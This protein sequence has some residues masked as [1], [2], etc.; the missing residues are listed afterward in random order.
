M[1]R[2]RSSPL[3]QRVA[4]WRQCT[5]APGI[6]PA[7]LLRI[8][9]LTDPSLTTYV[10]RRPAHSEW[11]DARGL[12]HHL[13]VWGDPADVDAAR[14]PLVM[15]HG[16]MDI[17][18]SFQFV[19]DALDSDRFVV[20][21]DL[22]GFGQTDG[23]NRAD[24]YW[25]PDYLADLEAL[26]DRTVD[27]RWPGLAVDLLGHSMGGNVAMLYAGIRPARVRRLISL[28]GFGMPET[29]PAQAPGRY[30]QW[31]DQLKTPADRRGY[32]TLEAVAERLRR[33][34]PLL[35]T[36]RARWL[37]ER[38]SCETPGR[39]GEA[40]CW[41]LL[42]DAAH[43][44]VN[45]VLY[46][47]DEVLECWKRITAPVLWIDGDRSDVLEH[48]KGTYSPQEFEARLAIV[49]RVERHRLSPAGHMLHHDQPEALAERIEHFLGGPALL[50]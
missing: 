2:Q 33:T 24:T 8:D 12:R 3:G 13:S 36:D 19:I 20:A 16:W 25:F 17:G 37:A 21:P 44:R 7:P 46:R 41:H 9:A 31:L 45:P 18:A 47:K 4:A 42:A 39:H 14:P 49:S 22:R 23:P 26:L 28:E 34:N 30:A 40:P 10:P 35:R 11:C 32:P 15:L 43:K 48:W 27:T 38:W 1:L 6:P 50:T 29:R 5:V